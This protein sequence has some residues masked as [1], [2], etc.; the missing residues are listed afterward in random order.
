MKKI[1]S[2][3]PQYHDV[4]ELLPRLDPYLNDN[5]M[6]ITVSPRRGKYSQHDMVITKACTSTEP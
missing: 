3:Y 6:H 5:Q 1:W 2:Y 4:V